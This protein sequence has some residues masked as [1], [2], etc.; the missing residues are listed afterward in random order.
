MQFSRSSGILLHI[1]SLPGQFEIGDLGES[2]FR[3]VDFLKSSGQ[4]IWQVLPL[5]PPAFGDSPYSSFSAFAGNELLISPTELVHDGL[6]A[7]D[8]ITTAPSAPRQSVDFQAAREQKLPMLQTAFENFAAHATAELREQFAGFCQR[9]SFWLMDFARF[10]ALKKHFGHSNWCEWDRELVERNESAL[11]EWDAKLSHD[12]EYAKFVQFI[13][14]RQWHKL[15]SYANANGVRIFGDMPIFVAYESADVW[16]N[17]DLFF[18]DNLG[19]QTVVAGVPPD[20]F[21]ETGQRWGNPLYR[22]ERIAETGYRW[23]IERFRFAFANFDLVRI[24]HFRGFESYWEVQADCP[25]AIDG[26]WQPGPGAAPFYAAQSELGDLPIIAED[27]GMITEEVHDLRDDLGFPGMRV[28]QFGFDDAKDPFHR[29]EAYPQNSAAYTGTHDNDTIMGWYNQR[30]EEKTE[31]P[32]L[33]AVIPGDTAEPNWE[34]L[35][36]VYSSEAAIA[37]A[38]MQDVLGLGSEHRMNTPGEAGGNWGWRCQPDAL[39]D[40][41]RSRLNEL[42][43]DTGRSANASPVAV[44]S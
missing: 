28:F 38:P 37:I 27:L 12:I 15:R 6:L 2:S 7:Q 42:T 36:A 20:Y 29:P 21:S 4:S 31:D 11:A 30:L 33:E 25:T 5:S 18:L 3:F 35:R 40:E 32:L 41:V 23:W 19:R 17:Q 39:C 26:K 13:F 16:A 22:W 43:S 8:D 9:N 1:T 14:D 34:M 10:T 24:D 44:G